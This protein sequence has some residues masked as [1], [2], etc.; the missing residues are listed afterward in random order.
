MNN[1]KSDFLI[2][3]SV[4][5]AVL[6]IFGALFYTGGLKFPDRNAFKIKSQSISNLEELVISSVGVELPVK[7]GNLG[8]QLVEI[9]AID[10]EKF[11]SIYNQRGGF[12]EENK[13]LLYGENNGNLT[14]N[15]ENAGYILNLFWAFGLANKNLILEQGPMVD[16]QYGGAGNFASTGGWTMAKGDAMNHYSKH[17]FIDLTNEQQALVERVSKNIY[18]PC[19]GNSTYFPDCN[20]GMAMLGLLELMA[21][22]GVLENDMYRVAL[23][24]NSY[25]FPDTYLTIAK[26]FQNRGIDWKDVDA[27]EV[28][29]SAYSSAL[30]Y[31]KILEEV[32]PPKSQ[33]GGGCG[34]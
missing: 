7:W 16:K 30:G 10:A 28:L 27:K 12:S 24:V 31:R 11:E 32:E 19:C 25:W 33:G 22:Q 14:I 8:K 13:K 9:G 26:Y 23:M 17:Q 5:I 29:S 34:V 2:P 1:K 21:S 20:H 3:F 4:L 6:L 15:S 18:R